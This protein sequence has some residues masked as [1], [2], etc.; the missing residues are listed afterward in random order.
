M[1]LALC[2]AAHCDARQVKELTLQAPLILEEQGSIALRVTVS[3]PD[4][5]GEREIS[6]HSRPQGAEES[7]WTRHASGALSQEPTPTPGP[8]TTWPPEGTRELDLTDFYPRL[9]ELGFEYGPVFQGLTRAFAEEER[10]YAEVSLAPEQ[11]DEAQG[12]AIHPA[13]TD[14]ALH[15]GLLGAMQSEGK[16]LSLQLPFA[17]RGVSLTGPGGASRARVALTKDGE[18][19]TLTI[20]DRDGAPLAAVASLVTREISTEQLRRGSGGQADL[21][22]LS[23]RELPQATGTEAQPDVP[24]PIE[25]AFEQSGDPAKDALAATTAT[26][27]LLQAHLQAGQGQEAEAPTVLSILTRGAFAAK[28][29]ESPDPAQ[30]AIAGL[31]RSAQSEHPGRFLLIDADRSDASTQALSAAMQSAIAQGEG[32][33]ALRE[34]EA[35]IPRAERL[36]APQR[37]DE[38]AAPGFDPDSTILISGGTGELGALFAQHLAAHHG[39]RHLLLASRSGAKAQGAKELGA[40]LEELGAEVKI[41]ACD[42]SDREQLAELIEGIDP[43]HPLGAVIHAAGVLADTL[44]E[45]MSPEA[46]QSVFTPKADAA[47]ALHELT[48]P[49]DLSAFVLFSSGAGLLGSPGQGN[50]AAANSFLDALA[51]KRRAQG[52][53]ATSIAWGLWER[54]S[55]MTAGLTDTDRA[56]M[57]RSGLEPI[58]DEHG[59]GLFER[60]LASG[61]P[62][63]LALPIDSSRLRSLTTAGALPPLFRSLIRLPAARKGQAVGRLGAELAELPAKERP[64]ATLEAVLAQVAAVLGHATPGAIDPERAFKEM[65]FDSLAAVELRNGLAQATGLSLQP[66]LVFD[67]PSP[68]ALATHLLEQATA[69]GAGARAAVALKASDEPIAILGMACRYPGGVTSPQELWELLAEGKDGISPF[70]RDRGW[71]LERLFDPDPESPGTTYA[72]EGGFIDSPADFD[73]DFFGIS[74]REALAMDPQQRLLLESCWEALEDAGV[75]PGELAGPRPGSSPG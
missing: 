38:D 23:W 52:L 39:A 15:A 41:A 22:A 13:L 57:A 27:E 73:P 67:Y 55:A 44:I 12:Y 66:T 75:D 8:L 37:E 47:Q 16:E 58:S 48:A 21:F 30:A 42:V 10:I 74:P 61:A 5:Q 31:I 14:S 65:G 35:L 4:E 17:W 29:G 19:L 34:G 64:K 70:P 20:A 36:I 54:E 60:S 43:E 56:R 33:L 9:A 18:E 24:E 45:K 62:L 72:S 26:L 25:P 32:Q 28:E 59:T 53:P 40:G 3:G 46:L 68:Q 7:E 11:S 50:Y 51:Q 49:L 63:T 1:E 71:D 2:A 69:S 6:I